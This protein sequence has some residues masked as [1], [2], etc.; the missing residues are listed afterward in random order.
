MTCGVELKVVSDRLGHSTTAI[1]A[2]LYTHVMPAVG[3]AA[4]DAIAA[5][6]PAAIE[7]LRSA[8]LA[9]KGQR[10]PEQILRTRF[11]SSGREPAR[12][13]EPRTARLQVPPGAYGQVV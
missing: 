2:D 5:S 9:Q 7:H 12:G 11:P 1:T 10:G 3:R 13:L 4:A 6:I 8:F